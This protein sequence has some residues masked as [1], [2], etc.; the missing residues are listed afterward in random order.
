MKENHHVQRWRK[1]MDSYQE[2]FNEDTIVSLAI[3][4]GGKTW[5]RAFR[6]D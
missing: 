3:F 4:Y 2:S 1:I 6:I 5:E